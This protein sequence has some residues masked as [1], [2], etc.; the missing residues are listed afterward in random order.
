[1]TST[2]ND[3]VALKATNVARTI[4]PNFYSKIITSGEEQYYDLHLRGNLPLEIFVWIA[5]SAKESVYKYL[6]RLHP[7]LIFSPSKMNL[8]Q[9]KVWGL[10]NAPDELEGRNFD[11]ISFSRGWIPAVNGAFYFRSILTENFIFTVVNRGN[12]FNDTY[13]GVKKVSSNQPDD[14]SREVRVFLQQKLNKL[15]P[16]NKF[17]IGKSEHGYPVIIDGENTLPI[18]VSFSHHDYYVGYSFQFKE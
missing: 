10:N 17:K 16:D 12:D 15:F 14:Q 3:I 8:F 13:W 11:D 1:M 7:E 5:W 9:L 2:G 4:Q 18:P 6:K